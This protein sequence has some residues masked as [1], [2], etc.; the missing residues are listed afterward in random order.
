VS[1]ASALFASL[2]LTCGTPYESRAPHEPALAAC[3]LADHAMRAHAARADRDCCKVCRKG[4]AC[5]DTCIARER[6]CQVPPGC[7]C[8][9]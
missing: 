6:S 4:K 9:Q 7:A 8:D 2:W 3:P 5:G 1:R